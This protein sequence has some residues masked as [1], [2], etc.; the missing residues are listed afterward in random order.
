MNYI[1]YI[2][3]DKKHSANIQ[4]ELY[5]QLKINKIRCCLEY[6]TKYGVF[7]LIV[8]YKHQI[9]A[10]VEIK[11]YTSKKRYKNTKFSNLYEEWNN[12]EQKK[13]YKKFGVPVFLC[14]RKHYIDNIIL[15]IKILIDDIKN[16]C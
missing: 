3:P 12:S 7:D 5:H 11:N 2:K 9:I 4:A 1:E 15:K 8:I 10:I 16:P 14:Y 13:R 6:R